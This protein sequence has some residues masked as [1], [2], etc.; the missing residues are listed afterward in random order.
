MLW[1]L[2][3]TDGHVRAARFR[4]VAIPLVILGIICVRL[5]APP[6]GLVFRAIH[7]PRIAG[8]DREFQQR[9][10]APVLERFR[11]LTPLSLTP[12]AIKQL[13]PTSELQ[14]VTTDILKSLEK[15]SAP[16]ASLP[17]KDISPEDF[18]K[19][20]WSPTD[21]VHFKKDNLH[22]FGA[23]AAQPGGYQAVR[24]L[25]IF[26]QDAGTWSHVEINY[27]NE[28]IRRPALFLSGPTKSL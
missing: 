18:W 21:I 16:P 25:T 4:F 2:L 28:F 14:E 22:V 6:G 23:V 13:A 24:W 5:A 26:R 1:E 17:I 15:S 19:F 12:E 8:L 7:P 27:Q 20:A 9:A 10:A 3:V 11:K